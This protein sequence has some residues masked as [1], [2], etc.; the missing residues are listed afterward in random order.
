MPILPLGFDSQVFY[1]HI[2][3][4][5]REGHKLVNFLTRAHSANDSVSFQ[6]TAKVEK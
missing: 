3:I 1:T 5:L 2:L 4:A 6:G